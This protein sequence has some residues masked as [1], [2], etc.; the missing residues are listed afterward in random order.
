MEKA[1]ARHVYDIE[2]IFEVV[3]AFNSVSDRTELLDIIL[4]KMMEIT[5][6]DSGSLYTVDDGKL[7]FRIIKNKTLGIFQSSERDEINLPPIVLDKSNIQNVSAY[8]AIKNEIVLVD[9]VYGENERF[10]LSGPKNYDKI[11]GYRTRAML[12]LPLCTQRGADNEVLGVIQM[13]N[14][15]DPVTGGYGVYGNIYEPPIVPALAKI[16][17]NTLSNLTYVRELRL[18]LR[19]FAAVMTQAIDERS[20]YNNNHT[21][22]IALY[23]ERFAMHLGH[24]FPQGHT[25]H[26]DDIRTESLVLAALLHDIGKIITPLSIMDKPDRLG[27]KLEAVRYRFELKKCQTKIDWLHKRI[28]DEQYDAEKGALSEAQA[29]VEHINTAGFL[30]DEQLENILKLRGLTYKNADGTVTALL[31][32]DNIDALSIRKGTLTAFEREIMQ[33]H[34][35]ITGRLLDK[36]PFWKYYGDIPFWARSHHEFLDGTGYP[37]G[38]SGDEI[39]IEACIITIVDIFEALTDNDRPYKKGM[40]IDKALK[41]LV[42]MADAGKLHKELVRLFVESKLWEECHEA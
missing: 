27:E 19:S 33:Q 25:L 3:L 13:M 21:Q 39:P 36:I 35:T 4:T 31:D 14:P 10:N 34:V 20:P 18:L 11:T 22:N 40:P 9:D 7:H 2:K 5:Y 16:A 32:E 28:N 42:E 1:E 26:F 29:F 6:S 17:A 24:V 37:Q 15:L 8:S 38:L 23:C 30:S 12:V 41:I